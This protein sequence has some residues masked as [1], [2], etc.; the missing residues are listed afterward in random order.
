ME[1]S[2][3]FWEHLQNVSDVSHLSTLSLGGRGIK[4][5]YIT[6]SSSIP[7]SSTPYILGT[8]KKLDVYAIVEL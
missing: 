2:Q 1:G 7:I 8:T 6:V 4:S 5:F 3:H